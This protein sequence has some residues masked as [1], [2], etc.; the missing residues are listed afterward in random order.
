[1]F[2]GGR[3]KRGGAVLVFPANSA[4]DRV[5][6]EDL[7]SLV[8]YLASVPRSVHVQLFPSSCVIESFCLLVCW[9]VCPPVP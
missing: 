5:R 3:D 1:M 6:Y 4:A 9:S 7:R 2:S 8:T